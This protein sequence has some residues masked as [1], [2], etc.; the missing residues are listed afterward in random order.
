[1]TKTKE[2][3]VSSIINFEKGLLTTYVWY[4]FIFPGVIFHEFAHYLAIFVSD[5]RI[6]KMV[7]FTTRSKE[8]SGAIYFEYDPLKTSIWSLALIHFAPLILCSLLALALYDS[9]FELM[10]SMLGIIL[11]FIASSIAFSAM[12]SWVDF[13]NFYVDMLAWP[14]KKLLSKN[15]GDKLVLVIL[16]IPWIAL[17]LASKIVYLLS[18]VLYKYSNVLWALILLLF[19]LRF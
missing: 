17:F 5:L 7:W 11:F 10:N 18:K 8:Y 3:R 15:L 6:K 9:A 4:V 12:P 1:M 16:F 19:S 14:A 13:K 2:A